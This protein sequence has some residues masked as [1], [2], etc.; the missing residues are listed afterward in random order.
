MVKV[1]PIGQTFP[2]Q[3]L[4]SL[5]D[6]P[7]EIATT[8][9]GIFLVATKQGFI[10]IYQVGPTDDD[11]VDNQILFYFRTVNPLI[12]GLAYISP[13]DSIITLERESENSII[14]VARIYS[15]WR[16]HADRKNPIDEMRIVT[17]PTA[18]SI[19]SLAVCPSTGRVAVATDSSITFFNTN[20]YLDLPHLPPTD[21][22]ELD[23]P[24][25][26]I[27]I[28]ISS[29]VT[30]M[31][32]YETHLAYCTDREVRILNIKIKM[33]EKKQDVELSKL[34]GADEDSLMNEAIN[35]NAFSATEDEYFFD[36]AFDEA[37]NFVTGYE[38]DISVP[39]IEESRAFVKNVGEIVGPLLDTNHIHEVNKEEGYALQSSTLVVSRRFDKEEIIH[40]LILVPEYPLLPRKVDDQLTAG[41]TMLPPLSGL[42]CFISTNQR[43]LLYDAERG[44]IVTNFIYTTDTTGAALDSTRVYAVTQ[45]GLEIWTGRTHEFAEGPDSLIGAG[46]TF[47]Y[48]SP[49]LIG[50]Q[51][52]IGLSSI[53]VA[54]EYLLVL[55][56]F[57]DEASPMLNRKIMSPSTPKSTFST[58]YGIKS[59]GNKRD[60]ID[61]NIKQGKT[62]GWNLYILDPIS[63]NQFYDELVAKA[64]ASDTNP[65]VYHQLILEAHLAVRSGLSKLYRQLTRDRYFQRGTAEDKH[66]YEGSKYWP[67]L[68]H[69][70]ALL[71]EYYFKNSNYRRAAWFFSISNIKVSEV[72]AKMKKHE[73][74]LKALLPYLEIVLFEPWFSKLM[75][76]TRELADEIIRYYYDRAQ[77]KL[78]F[79]VFDS[80]LHLFTKEKTL[81]L[82]ANLP[83][84][85]SHR[86]SRAQLSLSVNDTI[87]T[88]NDILQLD[89]ESLV[90]LMAGK[91]SVAVQVEKSDLG[92]DLP[93]ETLLQLLR[94][95]SPWVLL[96]ILV[97]VAPKFPSQ[98]CLDHLK[99]D[100]ALEA[101]TEVPIPDRVS[102]SLL[103]MCF[104][105]YHLL[106][107]IPAA[108]FLETL[109]NIYIDCLAL[110]DVK[111][112]LGLLE[113]DKLSSFFA[114]KWNTYHQKSFLIRPK[115]LDSLPPFL[116]KKSKSEMEDRPKNPF[117]RLSF[118][119]ENFYIRKLQGL[120]SHGKIK[121]GEIQSR[122][123]IRAVKSRISQEDPNFGF[124]LWIL[125]LP[126]ENN[127]EEGLKMVISNYSDLVT[128][129]AK[130]YCTALPEWGLVVNTLADHYSR[131][132]QDQ[133]TMDQRTVL[134][135][136]LE[137]LLYSLGQ[138]YPPE[139]FMTLLPDNGNMA[140][141][142]TFIENSINHFES[143]A[144]QQRL[145]NTAR[146]ED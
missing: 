122:D 146:F 88:V 49:C 136:P 72:V 103:L 62:I 81:S 141:F 96:E 83:L 93:T 129:Y 67:F 94:I 85:A 124:S 36:C 63:V 127:F 132:T 114:I 107:K 31:S 75:D 1:L 138:M 38:M 68:Q 18:K 8:D 137:N 65:A 105:E 119:Y 80:T 135:Q 57:T 82:L 79:V 50:M 99:K 46:P 131:L 128:A 35:P 134:R 89:P 98:W 110:T 39:S 130:E 108:N 74:G 87:T 27:E 33:E 84:Q 26:M 41:N 20:R 19:K 117:N 71:A 2:S 78:P 32:L 100:P 121:S 145:V 55:S 53:A 5:N 116:N 66:S 7:I 95:Y 47:G 10:Y 91:L 140:F 104:I 29:R 58:P 34:F 4:V 11:E 120:L 16:P 42:C 37:N 13:S 60:I 3:K 102:D 113:G 64:A 51:P 14:N 123:A 40:T 28:E 73:D 48:P 77:D 118:E 106:E 86:L 30:H 69:T 76:E 17:L 133:S 97:R 115:W 125:V 111:Q 56:K 90:D 12:V 43:G 45:S 109:V 101:K 23:T 70:A 24:E 59:P 143:I 54:G 144:L 44:S 22:R 61:D 6:E 52:F 15:K 21:S 92:I 139:E 25:R 112:Q 9:A 142:L 126:L